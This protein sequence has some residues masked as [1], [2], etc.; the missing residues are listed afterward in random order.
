MT[1]FTSAVI[2]QPARTANGMLARVSTASALVD[3]FYKIGAMRGGDV[4]PL[5]QAA[6]LEDAEKALRMALWSRDVRGGAGE[7]Q[8][9]RNM[10]IFLEQHYPQ[11]ALA[12]LPKVPEVGRWDDL[13]VFTKQLQPAAF[14][15]IREAL[16]QKN[17]LAA[18]WMPRKGKSRAVAGVFGFFTQ[19]LSQ[20]SCHFDCCGGIADVCQAVGC[21]Q[22]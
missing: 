12:L 4:L 8:H 1:T 13:L 9:F 21:H 15:L 3:L 7:R 18:K 2:N 17:G 20:N 22:L 6:L 16:Q 19:A 5:F 14:A 10:L 11:Y